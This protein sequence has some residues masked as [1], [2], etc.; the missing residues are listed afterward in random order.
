MPKNNTIIDKSHSKKELLFLIDYFNIPTG[1]SQK[2][3]KYEIATNLW[4]IISKLDYI[5]IPKENQYLINDVKDLRKYLKTRN[6]KKVLSVKEKDAITFKANKV[7]HY[8][9][10]GYNITES[11]FE[12]M[13]EL[14][15]TASHIS[16]YG[17]LPIVRKAVNLIMYDPKKLYNIKL[18]ISPDMMNELHV[19]KKLKTKAKHI[20]CDIKHGI[21]V[22]DFD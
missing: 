10:N 18:N 2:N 9:K 11:F 16:K 19:R 21:F 13:I 20:K 14:Y 12:D 6:P 17:D 22:I 7:I 3:N 5:S 8:C 15:D 4:D 1:L